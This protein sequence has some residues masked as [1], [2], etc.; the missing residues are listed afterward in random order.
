MLR[1]EELLVYMSTFSGSAALAGSQDYMVSARISHKLDLQ[2]P[3]M[4]IRTA[5]SSSM[6]ALNEA[7]GAIAKGDCEAAIVTGSN[8]LELPAK[9]VTLLM[10]DKLVHETHIVSSELEARGYAIDRRSLGQTL[11]QGQDIVA[12]L[13]EEEPFFEDI[14]AARLDQFQSMLRGLGNDGLLWVTQ[15]S[16]V[17]CT[18]P[19]YAQVIGLARTLRSEMAIDFAVLETDK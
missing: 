19:K 7:C 14:D 4:T 11:P 1:R 2:G 17:G 13:E 15:L 8:A 5:C 18:N 6:V 3:N 16:N 9:Q 12:L 10:S